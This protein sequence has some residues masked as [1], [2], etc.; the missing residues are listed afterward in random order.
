[1]KQGIISLKLLIIM[2][3]VIG[4]FT[5]FLSMI[6]QSFKHNDQLREMDII[7]DNA[8]SNYQTDLFASYGI[9]GMM[10]SPLSGTFHHSFVDRND[11]YTV[12]YLNPLNE[13][14]NLKDSI[15]QIMQIKAPANLID[16]LLTKLDIVKS[17]AEVQKVL[18]IEDSLAILVS[19][20]GH[21]Y[22][23]LS[24]K[25]TA[26]NSVSI[27]AI[28]DQVKQ[29]NHDWNLERL[30]Y[31][32]IEKSIDLTY[33]EYCKYAST[34]KLFT[35]YGRRLEQ[36]NNSLSLSYD[37]LQSY[38]EVYETIVNTLSKYESDMVEVLNKVIMIY[39]ETQSIEDKISGLEREL[40]SV[41]FPEL[42]KQLK[43]EI[44]DLK[45][46]LI[47]FSPKQIPIST[48]LRS[49]IGFDFK[50][51]WGGI[52]IMPY[53]NY[54]VINGVNYKLGKFNFEECLEKEYL[55]KEKDLEALLSLKDLETFNTLNIFNQENQNY[56]KKFSF[57]YSPNTFQGKYLQNV[58]ESNISIF[59]FLQ[60]RLTKDQVILNEYFLG[61]L[62]SYVRESDGHYDYYDKFNRSSYF[63]TCEV[64]FILIGN[65]SEL[66]D[67]TATS[68]LIYAS[69]VALNSVHIYLDKDKM[70]YSKA[71]GLSLAGWT[72]F[73]ELIVT[74]ALRLGWAMGESIFDM[75]LLLRGGN[76][77]VLKMSPD[78]WQL[79]LGFT[80]TPTS[81]KSV[82]SNYHDYLRLFLLL[83]PEEVKLKRFKLLLTENLNIDNQ[84]PLT[85]LYTKIRLKNQEKI[86]LEKSF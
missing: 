81:V 82:P 45:D 42:I 58:N 79:D 71:I 53:E 29:I 19:D 60:V 70:A 32:S 37:Q 18:D 27:K 64:E 26:I 62:R 52:L 47:L 56:V 40:E 31:V 17:V 9:F 12:E 34:D 23:E 16:Q 72:G 33:I 68:M 66:V 20:M 35:L 84:V 46:S 77:G 2:T 83:V 54:Q 41:D 24:L 48:S 74:N 39:S 61:T 21:S 51:P 49:F 78:E 15:K 59:D 43:N 75:D 8:L 28:I 86:I 76:V 85:D 6:T 63:E 57:N 44:D 65:E 4:I 50:D 55:I 69:R 36:L 13:I 22:E 38:Y 73:G 30:N 7:A 80:V 25:T 11:N 5:V 67:F 3:C 10:E 14:M 1:M